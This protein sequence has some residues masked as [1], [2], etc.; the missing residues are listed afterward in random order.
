KHDRNTIYA[1]SNQ[2]RDKLALV[3]FNLITGQEVDIIYENAKYDLSTQGYLKQTGEMGFAAYN[4]VREERHFIDPGLKKVFEKLSSH[5]PG[6]SLDIVARDSTFTNFLIK[7]ELDVDPG[8]TY[9]CNY[10]TDELILL[11]RSEER[12]VGTG[13][14]VARE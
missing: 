8:A 2:N 14:R 12:R 5:V 3:E 10:K 13:F 4:G 9:Y 11:A 1:L 6:Y 7:T